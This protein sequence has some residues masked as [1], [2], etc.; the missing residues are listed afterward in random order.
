MY[1]T[2]GSLREDIDESILS[3]EGSDAVDKINMSKLF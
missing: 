3:V 1:R 2:A